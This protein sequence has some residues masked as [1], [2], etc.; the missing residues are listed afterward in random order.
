MGQIRVYI[1][2]YDSP[3]KITI[4]VDIAEN[5]GPLFK[6][7][8]YFS[9]KDLEQHR[10][11]IRRVSQANLHVNNINL[12]YSNYNLLNLHRSYGISYGI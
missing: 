1:P 9:G 2:R 3:I 12:C 8:L 5:P 11:K 4:Y 10:F 6:D 7:L